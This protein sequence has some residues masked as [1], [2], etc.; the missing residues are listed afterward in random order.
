MAPE[1]AL[2]RPAD[3][4]SDV[5]AAG[6]IL[7]ELLAGEPPFEGDGIR[8][9]LG[10]VVSGAHKPLVAVNPAV[11]RPL[12]HAIERAMARDPNERFANVNE[13]AQFL[14][15]YASLAPASVGQTRS[16]EPIPL[17]GGA[18]DSVL[19]FSYEPGV[20]PRDFPSLGLAR[21]EGKP[22]GVPVADSLLA[23][24]IFPRPPAAP[25][26][27]LPGGFWQSNEPSY[28]PEARHAEDRVP[29]PAELPVTD[30]AEETPLAADSPTTEST[31]AAW[32]GTFVALL[33]G[34]AGGGVLA[35]LLH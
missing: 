21:V 34:A 22:R 1:Q 10:K 12:C 18:Q 23:R 29:D 5:Y 17:V 27:S 16:G 6:V 3:A 11:P 28:A 8:E 7:Y 32:S 26:I 19:V 20:R 2:G 33:V 14:R 15:P 9:V 13:L 30:P 25:K 35:L 24:P 31:A 4:R